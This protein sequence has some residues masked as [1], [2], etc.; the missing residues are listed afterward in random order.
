[1]GL[2]QAAKKHDIL[3][4]DGG[5]DSRRVALHLLKVGKLA[6]DGIPL[7]D[8]EEELFSSVLVDGGKGIHK[9]RPILILHI[10][11]CIL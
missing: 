2:K 9:I 3:V 5:N 10:R 8:D 6:A 11:K 4:Q 1:M 7:V